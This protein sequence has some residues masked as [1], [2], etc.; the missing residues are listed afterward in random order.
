MNRLRNAAYGL[1]LAIAFLSALV[2]TLPDV[3]LLPEKSE[4]AMLLGALTRTAL[5]V[6]L[7]LLF[8]LRRDG[9]A[10][11]FPLRTLPKSLLFCL[12]PLCVAVVN[13]PFSALASGSASVTHPER[14]PLFLFLCLTIG[15]TEELL[16]RGLLHRALRDV[17]KKKRFGDVYAVLLSSA[18]FGLWH[19][20]NLLEGA[21]VGPTLMQVGYT[22][23]LGAMFA[24]VY[25]R[26]ENIWLSV[27]LHTLFD[28]GGTLLT[29]T[30]SGSPHDT[31]FWVLTVCV[32]AACA[33]F[34]AVAAFRGCGR[35]Q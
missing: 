20:V 15:V 8:F 27:L 3:V 29:Y 31:V 19:L 23:L 2:F 4:N 14:I 13:F 18:V 24:V 1:A 35:K 5:A 25:D 16:F 12:L 34:I 30:G 11:R 6:F 7:L 9:A 33:V 32:G 26:T 17:F 22:F 10:L 21:G 28:V